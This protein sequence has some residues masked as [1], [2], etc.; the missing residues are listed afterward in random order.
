[1]AGYSAK[2]L[3]EKLG[4]ASG[5]MSEAGRRALCLAAPTGYGNLLGRLPSGLAVL[6]SDLAAAAGKA[7]ARQAPFDFI[8]AFCR[9]E[10]ELAPLFPVLKGLL[11]PDGMLWISWPKA[12]KGRKPAPGALQETQ[13]R[14]IGL[15]AGLV[16]VKVCAVD[17]TWS[18]LKF[19]YRLKD[20]S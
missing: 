8:Q 4:L 1:M 18:G 2:S 5:R 17:E 19:V 14:G 16:D 11:A 3:A 9:S 10:A 15:A 12:V 6:H 20:R 13:V 7:L